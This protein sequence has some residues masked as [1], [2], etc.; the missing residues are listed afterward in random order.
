MSANCVMASI[1]DTPTN[2]ADMPSAE[3]S[4][5]VAPDALVEVMVF[6]ASDAA[7]VLSGRRV[8]SRAQVGEGPIDLDEVHAYDV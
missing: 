4:R 7:R 6:L 1:I 3:F 5:W 2:R 8:A